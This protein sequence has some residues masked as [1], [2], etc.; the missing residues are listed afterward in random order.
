MA[1]TRSPWPPAVARRG[2]LAVPMAVA[3]LRPQEEE[4]DD[5]G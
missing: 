5:L 1:R 2:R 3:V 4:P